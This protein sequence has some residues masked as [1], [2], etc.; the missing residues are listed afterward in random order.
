MHT[1]RTGDGS[2][3]L[4]WPPLLCGY[5]AAGLR[6]I[7]QC[8]ETVPSPYGASGCFDQCKVLDI[9]LPENYSV[10]L[11]WLVIASESGDR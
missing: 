7:D 10:G 1:R 11:A 4:R 6:Y 2:A 8:P 3:N 9:I 5:S